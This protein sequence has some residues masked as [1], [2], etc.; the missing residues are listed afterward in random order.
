MPSRPQKTNPAIMVAEER[1]Q[2]AFWRNVV[3]YCV[4]QYGPILVEPKPFEGVLDIQSTEKGLVVGVEGLRRSL[5][6]RLIGAW[7]VLTG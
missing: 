1:K 7:R 5:K 6:T 2:Q 3:T 4:C